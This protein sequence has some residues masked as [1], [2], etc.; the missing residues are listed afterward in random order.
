[1]L[2]QGIEL[3]PTRRI[4]TMLLEPLGIKFVDMTEGSTNDF[5]VFLG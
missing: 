1:M 3:G 4:P 2:R 5:S